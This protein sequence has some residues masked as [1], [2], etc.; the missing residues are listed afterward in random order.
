M[1]RAYQQPNLRLAAGE[2]GDPALVKALQRDLRQLGYLARGIDGAFGAGTER[3][4]RALQWDLL[5]NRGESSGSDGAAPVSLVDYNRGRVVAVDGVL[6]QDLA[7]CLTD[8]IADD[9]VPKL[10][11]AEDPVAENRRALEAIAS[12]GGGVVPGPILQAI[13]IQE[14]GGRHYCVPHGADEDDFVAVGLD[15]RFGDDRVTS[16][17]YGIGQ[18][19][20]FHHPPRPEEVSSLM[21]DPVGNVGRAVR[22]LRQKFDGLVAAGSSR[23]DDRDAEHPGLPLRVCRYEPSDRRYLRDCRACAGEARKLEISEGTPVYRGAPIAY[24]PDRYYASADYSG[25]P[26]RADFLC[27]W[28]YAVRRYNGGGNDSYHYQTRVLLHLLALPA[29]AEPGVGD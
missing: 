14:S 6:E 20:L 12:A 7:A 25:V 1:Q 18:Y 10:P 2:P 3:A 17:G 28:P 19:T 5:N 13:S 23:A 26:D 27:D 8:L 24:R 21:L 29:P 4:V 22:V 9:S 11:N 15:R 16:R